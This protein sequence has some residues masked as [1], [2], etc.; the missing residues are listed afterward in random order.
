MVSARWWPTPASRSAASWLRVEVVKNSSTASSSQTGA[1]ATSTT[2]SAPVITSAR[3]SP[4]MV[5]TPVAG[6]AGTASCPCSA[7]RRTTLLPTR[8]LPPMTT[9]F[10][11]FL[12]LVV[13]GIEGR[14]R[15]CPRASVRDPSRA[16]SQRAC[17]LPEPSLGSA[18]A[19][20]N[21]DAWRGLLGRRSECE[22]LDRLLGSVRSGHSRVL[23]LRGEAGIGKTALLE[24]VVERAAGC[25]IARASGVESEMELPFAG[26]HQ[27]CAPMLDGLDGLPGPQQ[28]AL[29]VA[30]GLQEGATPDPFFVALAVLSLL[31]E[32][33]EAR[34]LVCVID[35]AQ[36]LDRGS[37]QALAFVARRLLAERIAM[38]FAVREPDHADELAGLPEL[39][40]KGIAEGD[41][42]ALLASAL[43]GI[44]DERIRDR[45][46][47]ET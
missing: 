16:P 31:A 37:A 39:V 12:P 38:V 34:P 47:A 6:E 43:P 1:L 13:D 10:M 14:L 3:P 26:L 11:V 5:S 41:A 2:T 35:D 23:V 18:S 29:R 9:I 44:L 17:G 30:F 27:L 4:V 25:R 40:V 21:R 28:D 24:Y 42:R 20:A 33:A 32:A 15:A 22:S 8:P 36:W 46:V 45:L 19:M 7:S